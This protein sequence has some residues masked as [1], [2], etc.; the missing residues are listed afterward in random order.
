M[1][2]LVS[3]LSKSRH[4]SARCLSR[5][6]PLRMGAALLTPTEPYRFHREY[7]RARGYALPQ[8]PYWKE[9]LIFL[10]TMGNG[11]SKPHWGTQC[12]CCSH[13]ATKTFPPPEHCA[14]APGS[15]WGQCCGIFSAKKIN[16]PIPGSRY[17]SSFL[18]PAALK[19]CNCS[20]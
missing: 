9:T 1:W 8:V 20:S 6:L 7:S 19:L 16:K 2:F 4:D 5:C 12:H 17:S 15:W 14:S 13:E 11:L 3:L 10:C 18:L